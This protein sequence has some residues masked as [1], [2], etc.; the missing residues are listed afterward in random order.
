MIKWATK[1]FTS[2]W[3]MPSTSLDRAVSASHSRH[4]HGQLV[5]V[6][7]VRRTVARFE[8]RAPRLDQV[9]QI[10]IYRRGYTVC[11]ERGKGMLTP[12]PVKA[13]V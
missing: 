13:Q 4:R 2:R 5:P 6:D 9:L 1:P 3:V 10:G 12:N 11:M 7:R 8:R